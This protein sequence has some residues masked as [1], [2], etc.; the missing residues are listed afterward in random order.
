MDTHDVCHW[1]T[2]QKCLN[3]TLCHNPKSPIISIKI[4]Y[5]TEK[6]G[7]YN[8]FRCES[9]QVSKTILN[10]SCIGREES[11][12]HISLKKYKSEDETSH[13]QTDTD[14]GE[15]RFLCTLCFSG[16]DILR[17]ERSH[18]L[19]ECARYQHCKVYDFAGNAVTRRSL[20]SEPIYK[21]AECEE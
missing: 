3:Q 12:Q 13:N 7:C 20:Q 9:S 10:N 8:C 21:S 17:D 5:H 6:N 11:G 16:T 15:H 2:N 14:S 1:Q 18:G 4:P 19:H